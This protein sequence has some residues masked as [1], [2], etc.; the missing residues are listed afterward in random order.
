MLNKSRER[1]VMMTLGYK[2]KRII[3]IQAP[4]GWLATRVIGFLCYK[5]HYFLITE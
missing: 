3:V 4:N 2:G 5:R 1:G